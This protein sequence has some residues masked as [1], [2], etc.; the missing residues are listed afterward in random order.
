MQLKDD[1]PCSW[2]HR[3][4]PWGCSASRVVRVAPVRPSDGSLAPPAELRMPPAAL[5]AERSGGLL[6]ATNPADPTDSEFYSY[7]SSAMTPLVPLWAAWMTDAARM[8]NRSLGLD[9]QVGSAWRVLARAWWVLL[10]AWWVPLDV[11]A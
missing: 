11:C 5:E 3:L 1:P 2:W 8:T 10:K 9:F 7:N 4:S 6:R